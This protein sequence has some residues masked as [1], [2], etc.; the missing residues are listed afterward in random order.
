MIIKNTQLKQ[1]RPTFQLEF[2][3]IPGSEFSVNNL[4]KKESVGIIFH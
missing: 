4:L 2:V 1:L 3:E